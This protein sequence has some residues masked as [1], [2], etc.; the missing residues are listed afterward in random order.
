M[1]KS[2]IKHILRNTPGVSNMYRRVVDKIKGNGF[3]IESIPT[4]VPVVSDNK[5]ERINLVLPAFEKDFVYGGIS[6]TLKIL[7]SITNELKI[8]ARIIVLK[9]S[10]SPRSSYKFEEFKV[11]GNDPNLIFLDD[12]KRKLNMRKS[13]IFIGTMWT[14]IYPI[15]TIIEKQRQVWKL[16][17]RKFVYLIQDY[18]PGFYKWSTEYVLCENTYKENAENIIAVFNAESLYKYFKNNNYDFGE[19]YWFDPVIN[20]VLR[21]KIES[22]TCKKNREKIILLYGRPRAD[23]NAF[24]LLKFSL[25]KWS[26]NSPYAKEWKIMS[27]GAKFDDIVLENNMIECKG[28]VSLEEYADIML[29]AYAAISLMISPHPSYPPLEFSTFGVR[30]ITNCFANKDLKNFNDNIIMLDV[31]SSDSIIKELDRICEE[32]ET[33]ESSF[34]IN[35]T[36]FHGNSFEQMISNVAKS[37]EKMTR[38]A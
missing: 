12:T 35:N 7:Q 2:E 20:G 17:H 18:E 37:V 31:C 16:S 21:K 34:G 24:E 4:V 6:T 8:E 25:K 10:Y 1:N 22:E 26:E 15:R 3:K 33:Y 14:T 11:Q 36:Y 5:K 9:G 32:Y 19:E 29:K 13:D 38:N 27:L 23:R 30:T 28:K